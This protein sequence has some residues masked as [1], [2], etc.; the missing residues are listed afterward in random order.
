MI[1]IDFI[2]LSTFPPVMLAHG[3]LYLGTGI[4]VAEHFVDL[5]FRD[6]SSL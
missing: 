1:R 6:T 2:S 4:E 3:C 5:R